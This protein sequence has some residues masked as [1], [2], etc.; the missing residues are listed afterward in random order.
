MK[1]KNK[2]RKKKYKKHF[3]GRE[4]NIGTKNIL[5]IKKL[6]SLEL[7]EYMNSHFK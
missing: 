2:K 7:D 4:V 6:S 1:K 5:N 3:Q